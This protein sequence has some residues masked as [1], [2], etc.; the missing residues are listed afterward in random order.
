MC[1]PEKSDCVSEYSTGHDI[2]QCG[3]GN[4]ED[5]SKDFRDRIIEYHD[6]RYEI[7]GNDRP[8]ER[9]AC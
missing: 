4:R 3:G 8:T 2:R 5:C 7:D 9:M 1:V 6:Y